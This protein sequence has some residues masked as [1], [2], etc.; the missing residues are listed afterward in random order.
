MTEPLSKILEKLSEI[1]LRAARW[2]EGPL[3]VLAGPGS[4]KTS[5][6]TTRIGLLLEESRGKNFRILALTFTTKAADEMLTR[7]QSFVPDIENRLFVGTFHSFCMN[8]LRQHGIHI[9]IK[10]DFAIYSQDEERRALLSEVLGDNTEEQSTNVTNYLG[11][12]DKLKSRLIGVDRVATVISSAEAAEKVK[13]IY[14]AYEKTLRDNNAL[15]F[16]SL[17]FE[18]YR[19]FNEFP[20]IAA[21]YRRTYKYWLIDEFQDTNLAQYTLIKTLAG[22]DLKNIFVVADDDQIIYQWN[23]ASY[24][25][26]ERYRA[27]FAPEL[28]QLPTN[29]RCPPAIVNAAN[30]LVAN[31][32]QRTPNKEPL[33]SG[34]TKLQLPE[35]DHIRV[36]HFT[37]E[38]SE[39]AAIAQDIAGRDKGVFKEVVVL[40]RTRA[41]LKLIQDALQEKQIQS[42]IAQRRDTFLSPCFVWLDACLRQS[43]RPLDKRSFGILVESFNRFAKIEILPDL[44]ISEAEASSRNYIEQWSDQVQSTPTESFSELAKLAVGLAQNVNNYKSFIDKSLVIFQKVISNTQENSETWDFADDLSAWN[45][46]TKEIRHALGHDPSLHEFVQELGM[47]SKEPPIKDSTVSLMT[48]HGAKGKEFEYVYLAGMAEEVLPSFQSIRAGVSSLEMEE[49]RRNC[50]VAITRTKECL[51]LSWADK[52]RGYGKKPSRFLHEMGFDPESIQ[53]T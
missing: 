38:K 22:S 46:L 14:A 26:I 28:I 40:A 34:K 36:W 30:R 19:L 45:D 21:Q 52:Y 51:T 4:G 47:R 49:E 37:D 12:I 11:I 2:E 18:T 29:F 39:A 10:S 32:T 8:I 48:I 9:G 16:N 35:K 17:I 20:A 7:I 24:K 43:I 44:V 50:F 3:L 25:Q 41:Q 27:D 1:Q 31:N 13:R 33:L 5:V 53:A 42:A 23:G 15:D 6:L